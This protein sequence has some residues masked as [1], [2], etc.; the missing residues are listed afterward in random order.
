V[1]LAV[2]FG[3][4]SPRHAIS[5]VGVLNS[6]AAARAAHL[7][8]ADCSAEEA[9]VEARTLQARLLSRSQQ[10]EQR[11]A[12]FAADIDAKAAAIREDA[13]AAAAQR[14]SSTQ[15]RRRMKI[16]TIFCFRRNRGFQS[17]PYGAPMNLLQHGL[18]K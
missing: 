15:V 13:I 3:G 4:Y 9:Q 10:V 12:A 6:T 8:C 18:N 7:R 1:L 5:L 2:A 14:D 11:V 16:A 17:V